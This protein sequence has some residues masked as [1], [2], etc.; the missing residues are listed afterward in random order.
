MSL[1]NSILNPGK[2]DESPSS[3]PVSKITDSS[4]NEMYSE[5]EVKRLI[6]Q[7]GKQRIE[8]ILDNDYEEDEPLLNPKN[9]KLTAF[10]IVYRDIWNMYKDQLAS[11]WKAEEIDFSNDYTDFLTLNKDEQYFIEMVL[12]FFAASDGIV[13]FNLGERFTKEIKV[14][15]AL[16]CYQFQIMIENIHSEVY[17][18]MLENIVRDPERRNFLFNAVQNVPAVNKMAEWAFKW[19][20]SN[21]RF[22]FRIVAFAIVEGIFFSG[23]FAAI[24]WMK[25]YKNSHRDGP[26]GKQFMEGLIKSNKFIS[27][28][29]GMHCD[30]ACL[31]YNHVTHKLTVSEINPMMADACAVAKNFMIESLPVRLIGMNNEMM[32]DYIEYVSDRLLVALGYKKM[33]N[34]KNPFKFMETIGLD[35]KTNFFEMRPHEYQDA[36]VKNETKQQKITINDDF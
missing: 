19:I 18:L 9:F 2:S 20:E 6:K 7:I 1:L 32:C 23:M 5:T 21:E 34:K 11:F 25:K 30:F 27:R 24:F 26:T 36:Y 28:D 3:L 29:E 15:E 16:T 13:N 35:D 12:A 4:N 14:T 10:P 33:F 17:S 31:L 8:Q 22:A